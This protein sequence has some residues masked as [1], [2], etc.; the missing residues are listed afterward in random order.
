MHT[1]YHHAMNPGSR[2]VRLLLAE[3]GQSVSF[4]EEKVWQRR[5]E[6]LQL[7]PSGEVPVL[8]DDN[9]ASV[10]GAII[11]GEFLDETS[12]ALMRDKRLMPENT[13][14]RAETRRLVEWFLV[15]FDNE[16]TRYLL[17]ER[18]FKQLM[19]SEEGGGPPDSSVIRAARSNL[20]NHMKYAAMLASSRDWLA[21]G[22]LS[23]SDLAAA[24]ALSVL[25]YLGEVK[26]EEEPAVKDWYARIKSR[27]SFRPLLE[28]KVLGL[29]PASHYIDLDF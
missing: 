1:L 26:W 16:V 25:D 3:Y 8:Q 29:P 13:A 23:H 5:P 15:K 11:I 20:K 6:F 18:V 21:G 19:R 4:L 27:P 17:Q 9:G 2:Y 24:A 22:T 14:D 7:N 10:C 12:G 28:D